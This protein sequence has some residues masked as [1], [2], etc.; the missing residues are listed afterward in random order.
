MVDGTG[1]KSFRVADCKRFNLA[2]VRSS[3]TAN[4]SSEHS[5]RVALLMSPS[6]SLADANAAT[7]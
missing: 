5:N 1:C 3:G 6:S 2:N 7:L 4:R